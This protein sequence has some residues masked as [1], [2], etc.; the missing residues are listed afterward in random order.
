MAAA[1]RCLQAASAARRERTMTVR[2]RR[3][4]A[5]K[6]CQWLTTQVTRCDCHIDTGRQTPESARTSGLPSTSM[7]SPA[8][9]QTHCNLVSKK[10]LVKHEFI[11]RI[12]LKLTLILMLMIIDWSLANNDNN[13]PHESFYNFHLRCGIIWYMAYTRCFNKNTLIFS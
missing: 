8:T 6:S 4:A 9:T 5:A 12:T 2:R 7:P 11:K 1:E 3:P 13:A 10:V